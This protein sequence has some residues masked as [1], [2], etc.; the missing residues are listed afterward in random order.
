ML[1]YSVQCFLRRNFSRCIKFVKQQK[2]VHRIK[3]NFSSDQRS[4]YDILG[5]DSDASLKDIKKAYISMCKKLHPDSN[6]GDPNAQTNFVRLN[7]AYTILS[8]PKKRADYDGS[9]GLRHKRGGRS[10][11]SIRRDMFEEEERKNDLSHHDLIWDWNQK[12]DKKKG[13]TEEE[14]LEQRLSDLQNRYNQWYKQ[15]MAELAAQRKAR[16]EH[17]R[18]PPPSEQETTFRETAAEY[19]EAF[20]REGAKNLNEEEFSWPVVF[21]LL[22]HTSAQLGIFLVCMYGMYK[23]GEHTGYIEV[24]KKSDEK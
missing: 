5:V 16:E 9:V 20:H 10:D 12:R 17:W 22:L 8:D 14:I 7:E 6:Q 23:M 19:K 4:H 15:Y 1:S 18:D 21:G 13:M 2:P 11:R 24:K 3:R